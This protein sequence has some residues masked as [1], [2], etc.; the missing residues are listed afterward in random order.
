MLQA[1]GFSTYLP[2]KSC[3]P[4]WKKSWLVPHLETRLRARS[5]T[6]AEVMAKHRVLA[7][8]VTPAKFQ[9][10]SELRDLEDLPVLQS[11]VGGQAQTIITG[12]KDLLVLKEFQGIVIVTPRIFITTIAH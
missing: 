12:D 3:Y 2:V 7:T 5:R 11:A 10:P 6:V 4:N 8:V 9:A 1:G